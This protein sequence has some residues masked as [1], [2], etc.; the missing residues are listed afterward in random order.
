MNFKLIR[1][2][3]TEESTVGSLFYSDELICHTLE[4][5]LRPEKSRGTVTAIPYGTY[6]LVKTY[7]SRFNKYVPLIEGVPGYYSSMITTGNIAKDTDG[8]IVVGN[9][10][11][12]DFLGETKEAFKDLMLL[13]ESLWKKE[14]GIWI[15]ICK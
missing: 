15:L 13:L 2:V 8:G 9:V 1:E 7:S 3:F 14:D 10:K 5:K 6:K 12:Q 4:G 11:L